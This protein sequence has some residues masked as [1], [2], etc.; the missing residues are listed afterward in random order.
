MIKAGAK[1]TADT[2]SERSNKVFKPQMDASVHG[3]TSESSVDL[4]V[5]PDCALSH[6]W[7]YCVRNPESSRYNEKAARYR[8]QPHFNAT[9]EQKKACMDAYHRIG[10]PLGQAAPTPIKVEPQQYSRMIRAG[11]NGE[12]DVILIGNIGG[13][14]GVTCLVD[15]GS[16]VS[17][18]ALEWY[19]AHR[20]SL[21]EL[22]TTPEFNLLVANGSRAVVAGM[23]TVPTQFTD[24]AHRLGFTRNVDYLVM[25][26]LNEKVLL[27][28]NCLS[29]F[30][31]G[32]SITGG[33]LTF[34][35]D[36]VP[37]VRQ[38]HPQ[39]ADT[40]SDLRITHGLTLPSRT[41]RRVS[42]NYDT[43]LT[44][45]PD[46]PI[47]CRPVPLT[48]SS[49]MQLEFP[50]HLQDAS[51]KPRGCYSILVLNPSR[52]DITLR[53]NAVIGRAD[54]IPLDEKLSRSTVESSP[55]MSQ[56]PIYQR[57]LF[58]GEFSPYHIPEDV[59]LTRAE[60]VPSV[61]T[62]YLR[63]IATAGYDSTAAHILDV[64]GDVDM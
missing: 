3:I 13:I 15:T 5:C 56:V 33:H 45:Y 55:K 52:S 62:R 54:V 34:R 53:A 8:G 44:T 43:K 49:E 39:S 31:S 10:V 47:I 25:K 57:D 28:M 2:R 32:I 41:V 12:R 63:H 51:W 40:F 46:A 37:D 20:E 64:D 7:D 11:P 36:L 22:D 42:V 21:G 27:G 35:V 17:I 18:I 24:P 23:V 60:G 29:I 61:P 50:P 1:R 6:S 30:F 58:T 38:A 16:Q 19:E 4:R 48:S 59:I 26:G 14:E 9:P